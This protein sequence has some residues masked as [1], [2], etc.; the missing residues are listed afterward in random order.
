MT[1]E[2]EAI[3]GFIKE[4][5]GYDGDV[6]PE[7]DLLEKSILNSFNVVELALFIQEHFGIELQADDVT[8]A[9]FAKLASIVALIDRRQVAI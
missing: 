9:N 2:M 4:D 3:L 5:F 1:K 7:V 6:D 8:R